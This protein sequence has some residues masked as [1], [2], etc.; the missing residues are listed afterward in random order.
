MHTDSDTKYLFYQDRIVEYSENRMCSQQGL[1]DRKITQMQSAKKRT[2]ELS[3]SSK[4]NIEKK[5]TAF[6]TAFDI[7]N[8]THPYQKKEK[9]RKPIFITLTLSDKTELSH[10]EIKRQLLQQFI[11][12]IRYQFD[13]KEVFWKA[14]L[15]KNNNLHFHLIADHYIPAQ[16]IQEHW[17]SIQKKY[18]LLEHQKRIYNNDSPPSTHVKAVDN[19]DNSI[20]YVMKYVNK[21][22]KGEKIKGNIYR[23]SKQLSK[24]RPFTY[25]YTQDF[26][27][28]FHDYIREN[29]QK[30]YHSDYFSVLTLKK[31]VNPSLMPDWLRNRF[32]DYYIRLYEQLYVTGSILKHNN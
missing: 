22:V 14:E 17:N 3:Q 28:G 29:I 27:S 9:I 26:R 11:K 5:L 23:M 1:W 10:Q 15:Q 2:G 30:A 12:Q 6:L 20:A 13:V 7:Y 25:N 32:C 18:G 24:L 21:H 31:E 8:K 16:K 19:L 4:K